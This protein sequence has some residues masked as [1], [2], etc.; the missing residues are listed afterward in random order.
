MEK[1][2]IEYHIRTVLVLLLGLSLLLSISVNT[3]RLFTD[4]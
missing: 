3:V 2:Q 4:H 1:E